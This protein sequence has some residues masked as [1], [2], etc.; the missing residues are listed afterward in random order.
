MAPVPGA[1]GDFQYYVPTNG[2]AEYLP[3]VGH[4]VYNGSTWVNEGLLIESEQRTNL[5][6]HSD[7]SSGWGETG[8]D[9]IALDETGPDG[10][11]NTAVTLNEDSTA[12]EHKLN[13]FI[14]ALPVST[15]TSSVFVK[16]KPSDTR[17]KIRLENS[18]FTGANNYGDFDLSAGTVTKGSAAD[19]ATIENVGNGWFRC[20][21][22]STSTAQAGA[23][24]TVYLLDASGNTSYTGDGASGV[25]I[26]GAQLDQGK[27]VNGTPVAAPTP[28]SYIPTNGS[29]VIRGGQ[30]L[31]VPPAEFGW[32][33]PEYIGPDLVVEGS[34]TSIGSDWSYANGVYT[35]SGEMTALQTIIRFDNI[36]IEEGKVYSVLLD[37][38]NRTAGDVSVK[39]NGG[40]ITPFSTNGTHTATLVGLNLDG[41]QLIEQNGFDGDVSNISVREI[42]P[43]SVSIQMDGRM[44]YADEGRGGSLNGGSG[45]AV[46]YLW[47]TDSSNYVENYL[48]T[49]GTRTGT[50]F[51]IQK[52][53][54]I[55]DYPATPSYYS[56]GILTPFNIASR[57]GSTF[58]NGAVDG[59]ALTADTTPTALPDLSNT[60]LQIAYDFM[61]T[62]GTF[63]QFA[64]DIG[65][66]GLVTATNPSTEPTL[67]LTFDGTSGSFY[68]LSWSE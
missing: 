46:F 1:V 4:H 56:P 58:I 55:R 57:H 50:P 5:I 66:A 53:G 25:L 68:N 14:A 61:G 27:V 35:S 39:L 52:A 62:I 24:V 15:Y 38:A 17:T 60:D 32:P 12:G 67:S 49:S 43:L 36:G 22:T 7:F 20:S 45:E 54:G 8:V 64:G 3:R 6:Q 16:L 48:D 18:N 47:K 19:S 42:N 13:E 10:Q 41:F 40:D 37:I 65:D 33:E 31:V 34:H 11:A 59:V 2:A 23:F 28:S 51:A 63:R 26:Y 44:T 9:P 30:S 29:T 21:V